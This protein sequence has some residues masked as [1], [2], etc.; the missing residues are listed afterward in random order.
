[1]VNEEYLNTLVA[2]LLKD[3]IE[4]ASFSLE[5]LSQIISISYEFC[6]KSIERILLSLKDMITAYPVLPERL[7][8][9]IPSFLRVLAIFSKKLGKMSS[10]KIVF[11]LVFIIEHSEFSLQNS[12]ICLSIL[13]QN[14]DF[15][16]E[17]FLDFR[18]LEVLLSKKSIS[19]SDILILL[20][21]LTT[22]SKFLVLRI[23]EF[24]ILDFLLVL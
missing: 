21:S 11:L 15:N 8:L 22:G 3:D 24:E 18:G 19:K 4:T 2:N 13:L 5:I 10:E 7:A 20:D 1:L 23:L 12:V 14:S 6:E 16:I 17:N 9:S